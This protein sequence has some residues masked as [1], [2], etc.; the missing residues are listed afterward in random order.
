MTFQAWVAALIERR[1]RT[2]TALADALG[3][4]LSPFTRGVKAGTLN[5]V[6]LLKLAKIAEE[7]PSVVLR[8]ARKVEEAEL[9]EQLYGSGRDALTPSQKDF[10]ETWDELGRAAPDVQ[11]NFGVLLRHARN[12]ATHAGPARNVAVPE[13]RRRRRAAGSRRM[14]VRSE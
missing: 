10:L 7:H 2:A 12:V 5:L 11:A 13:A 9:L 3:M 4:K 8:L 1:F 6:N 14:V